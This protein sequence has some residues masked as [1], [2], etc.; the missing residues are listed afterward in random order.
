M[1][2]RSWKPKTVSTGVHCRCEWYRTHGA[3]RRRVWTC[4]LSGEVLGQAYESCTLRAD[5]WELG[6]VVWR[7]PPKG[8]HDTG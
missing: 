1:W 7:G 3:G 5:E 8:P 6:R 2:V 4:G